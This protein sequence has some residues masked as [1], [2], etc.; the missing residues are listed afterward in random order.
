MFIIYVVGDKMARPEKFRIIKSPPVFHS[1]KPAGISIR[2]LEH[3]Y[4][5][6]S[7]YEAIRLAD[8]EKLDHAEAAKLMEISRPTFSR[9]IEKA[10]KKVATFILEGHVLSIEGGKIHFSEN[11][12]KCMDCGFIFRFGIEKEIKKCEK[13]SSENISNFA[14][15]FGHGRCCSNRQSRGWRNN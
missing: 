5:S 12:I 2:Q 14:M 15:K 3:I 6:L 10:R 9:L 7:E 11:L 8:Y 1:F 13:C 4:L